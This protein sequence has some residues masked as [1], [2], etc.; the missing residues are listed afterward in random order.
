[1]I[2]HHCNI[3]EVAD[4]EAGFVVGRNGEEIQN[5]ISRILDDEE[6]K[7]KLGSNGRRMVR[8]K[9]TLSKTVEQV[10]ELYREV[11][12]SASGHAL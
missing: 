12:Y 6:L 7:R 4:Y 8:E 5:A 11:G 10:E 9:F 3:P 2:T 1:M